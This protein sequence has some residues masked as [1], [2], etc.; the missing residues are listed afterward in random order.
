MRQAG[1]RTW[2]VT[3]PLPEKKRFLVVA[4]LVREFV[5]ALERQTGRQEQAKDEAA[6]H[7]PEQAGS[8]RGVR[9]AITVQKPNRG[10]DLGMRLWVQGRPEMVTL[11]ATVVETSSVTDA[12]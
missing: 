10:P 3:P 1:Y 8:T 7:V 6:A 2:V 5:D 12:P 4:Q 11:F 9:A